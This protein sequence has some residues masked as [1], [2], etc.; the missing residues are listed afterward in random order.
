MHVELR[1]CNSIGDIRGITHFS[2]V[3][4]SEKP[5]KKESAR[6]ICSFVNDMRIN[7]NAA[8]AF[9]EYLGLIEKADTTSIRTTELGLVTKAKEGVDLYQALCQ[10]CLQKVVDEGFLPNQ[11]IK[12]DLESGRYI[13]QKNGFP[14]SAAV[15]R[16]FLIQL[17]A[18]VEQPN[19]GLLI[20]MQYEKMFATVQKKARRKLSLEDLKKK[21]E[22]QEE[23]G[24]LAEMFV[25]DY[26]KKRLSGHKLIEG[27]KQISEID[28]TAGYDIISYMDVKSS[29]YD[30][31][32]EVKSYKGSPHFYWSKNEIEVAALHDSNYFIY[33]VDID[34]IQLP[35]YEP[36]II[37]NPSKTV[38]DSEKWIVQS[39]SYLVIPVDLAAI[40]CDK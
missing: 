31:F 15:F 36:L 17:K 1:R 24:A 9:Y 7:F 16:N 23:Q 14:I 22:L 28:V 21:L 20:S 6:Q 33:L 4:L 39:A 27:I 8:L 18:L 19:G 13:I 32:I 5:V 3:I 26:E 11:V 29:A 40:V 35:E 37:N 34:K 25:L 38:L 10:L 2:S 12:F 30:R